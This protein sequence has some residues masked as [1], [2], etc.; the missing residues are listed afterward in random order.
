VLST[1]LECRGIEPRGEVLDDRQDNPR[2]RSAKRL[3]DAGPAKLTGRRI[4]IH[5]SRPGEADAGDVVSQP[6]PMTFVSRYYFALVLSF[7]FALA[8]IFFFSDSESLP[9]LTI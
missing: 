2:G 9:F 6:I 4:K 8:S 7:L 3:A 5:S 1:F